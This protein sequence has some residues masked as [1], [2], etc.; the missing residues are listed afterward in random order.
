MQVR[1]GVSLHRLRNHRWLSQSV[2]HSALLGRT[3]ARCHVTDAGAITL[4]LVIQELVEIGGSKA[5]HSHEFG[6]ERGQRQRPLEASSIC[7]HGG[8][9]AVGEPVIRWLRCGQRDPSG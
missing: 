5:R 6:C 1:R 7:V 3:V 2:R 9:K 4:N 8:R